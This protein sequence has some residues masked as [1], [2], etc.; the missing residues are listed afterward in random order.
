MVLTRTFGTMTSGR[1][2]GTST[3]TKSMAI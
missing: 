3:R 2:T 1:T